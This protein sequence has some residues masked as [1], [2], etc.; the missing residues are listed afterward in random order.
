MKTGKI[1]SSMEQIR[2]K[3]NKGSEKS[4]HGVWNGQG[5]NIKA[6]YTLISKVGWM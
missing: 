3:E 2:V 1:L 4:Q 5:R 6:E